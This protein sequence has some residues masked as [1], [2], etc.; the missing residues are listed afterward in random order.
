MTAA[1][2][3]YYT[4]DWQDLADL[5]LPRVKEYCAAHR[6]F[7][8][9]VCNEKD[10]KEIGFRKMQTLKT[11]LPLF[12]AIWVLDLDTLITNT[13]IRFTSFVDTNH[14]IFI[15]QDIHGINA[16]S[17][18]ARN[19]KHTM[20]FIDDVLNDFDAPEEQTVMKRHI[21]RIRVKILP[22]P[23]INSYK[24]ELYRDEIGERRMDVADG[25]WNED[26]LLLHLP[27]IGLQKRIEIFKSL[28]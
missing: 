22:H 7:I 28:I 19:T 20:Q 8:A 24:Y 9:I 4:P 18:I 23:S 25:E 17:W 10:E 16:G 26:C 1:I 15:T 21:H 27:G 14:D 5:V 6:Y 11:A 13:S 2:Y 12:D 3:I